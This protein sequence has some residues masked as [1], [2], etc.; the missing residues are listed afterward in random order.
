MKLRPVTEI[1]KR[2]ETQSK[3]F[4]DDVILV[5]SDVIVIFA[6]YG[7]FGA[8]QKP[9]FRRIVYETY[10]FIESNLFTKTETELKYL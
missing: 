2:N 8:I 4:Y 3:T 7:K 9:D 5:N 6:I 1:D 10:I